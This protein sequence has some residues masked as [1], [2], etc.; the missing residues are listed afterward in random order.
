[1]ADNIYTNVLYTKLLFTLF[2]LSANLIK[3]IRLDQI[4]VEKQI[5]KC[6]QFFH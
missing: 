5:Q 6:E 1:M 2:P 3:Q 4:K